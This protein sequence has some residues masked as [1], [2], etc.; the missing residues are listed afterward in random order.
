LPAPPRTTA[1][2]FLQD[3]LE[4]DESVA[5][6]LAA[7]L[8]IALTAAHWEILFFIRDYHARFRHLP[9][10]R[11]FVKAVEKSLGIEKGN[12]RYLNALFAGSPVRHA[13]LLAGLPKPP[14]CL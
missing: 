11:M 13:C 2:G 6:T 14:G 10:N 4:W 7:G 12:S 9:N 3:S 1:D 8:D 5:R